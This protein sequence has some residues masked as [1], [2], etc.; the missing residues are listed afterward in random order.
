MRK[1]LTGSVLAPKIY[2]IYQ[3][4]IGTHPAPSLLMR[5]QATPPQRSARP[6]RIG[7]GKRQKIRQY[8]VHERQTIRWRPSALNLF[9]Q[10]LD[11]LLHPSFR[12]DRLRLAE[13]IER[14]VVVAKPLPQVAQR[15]E[16]LGVFRR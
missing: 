12:I 2:V 1:F 4:I 3:C 13:A 10:R 9:R 6:R 14:F 7:H 8:D 11:A 15:L 16:D 5:S